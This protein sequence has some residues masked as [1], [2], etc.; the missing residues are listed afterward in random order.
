MYKGGWRWTLGGIA[1]LVVMVVVVVVPLLLQWLLL[2][3]LLL[4]L[5][6]SLALLLITTPICNQSAHHPPGSR[7]ADVLHKQCTFCCLSSCPLQAHTQD[8]SEIG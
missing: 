5:L 3:L 8:M 1:V 6:L 2:L 4:S 7:P